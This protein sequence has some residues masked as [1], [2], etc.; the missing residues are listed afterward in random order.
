[1]ARRKPRRARTAW[2]SLGY[3]LVGCD[4][5]GVNAFFVLASDAGRFSIATLRD[6]WVPP[7]YLLPYGHPIRPFDELDVLPLPVESG[8]SISLR[9]RLPRLTGA[10]AGQILYFDV[11]VINETD[12]P[13]ACSRRDPFQLATGGSTTMDVDSL[14]SRTGATNPGAHRHIRRATCSA[15][16]VH[17]RSQGPIRWFCHS[18]M[19]ASVG[20]TSAM[21]RPGSGP[22]VAELCNGRIEF[23]EAIAKPRRRAGCV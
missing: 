11:M 9:A 5:Q 17:P 13:I 10:H 19:K 6:R 12:H 4:S 20:S 18:F 14:T 23:A 16:R 7:R 21:S 2:A 15:E 3:V 8:A 1:M 22:F